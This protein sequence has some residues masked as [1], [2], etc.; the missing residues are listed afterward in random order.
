MTATAA[1]K[2]RELDEFANPAWDS[3]FTGPSEAQ[4]YPLGAA[5]VPSRV[6]V[7]APYSGDQSIFAEMARQF[8]STTPSAL[9]F[10]YSP[11]EWISSTAATIELIQLSDILQH[12]GDLARIAASFSVAEESASIDDDSFEFLPVQAE[13]R[14]KA[15]IRVSAPDPT[16]FEWRDDSDE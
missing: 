2:F 1:S 13:F 8:V 11:P 6:T 16:P 5:T 15:R 9:Q 12:L 4:D 7:A 14:A 10:P 3:N